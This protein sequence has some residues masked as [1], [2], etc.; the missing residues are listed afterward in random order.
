[1]NK[2]PSTPNP[3]LPLLA[4]AL[5]AEIVVQV[6]TVRVHSNVARHPWARLWYL[7]RAFD[8]EGT[9]YVE[10]PIALCIELLD[11]SQSTIYRWLKDGAA[12]GA[13]RFGRIRDGQLDAGLG[14]LD[15]ICRALGLE[16]WG[17][18]GEVPL[19]KLMGSSEPPPPE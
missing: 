11:V 2:N 17:V 19:G 8:V 16:D 4:L 13:F 1:M 7:C 14:G 10:L 3:I 5:A 12:A 6:F 9:G 15:K 18:V